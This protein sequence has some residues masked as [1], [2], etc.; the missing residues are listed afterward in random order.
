MHSGR[1]S[2]TLYRLITGTD[3][4]VFCHRVTE[5]LSKGW[6]LYGQPT[7]TFDSAANR[8]MCGQAVM[9]DVDGLDY[10]TDLKLGLQ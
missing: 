10:S 9:K 3:D 7:M 5:A 4:S 1:K 8:V 2:L 6:M